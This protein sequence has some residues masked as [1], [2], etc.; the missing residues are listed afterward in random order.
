[1]AT[2]KSLLE[3]A[4]LRLGSRGGRNSNEQV[5][6]TVNQSSDEFQRFTAPADGTYEASATATVDNG[7]MWMDDGSGNNWSCRALF[8]NGSLIF[9]FPVKKGASA[10]IQ[11]SSMKNR[12]LT[13]VKSIGGCS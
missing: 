9:S 5:D 1:M 2:I 13:F 3:K 11:W 6:L 4:M 12:T 10:G 8:V 7:F